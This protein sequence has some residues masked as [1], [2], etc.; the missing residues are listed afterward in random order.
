MNCY[1]RSVLDDIILSGY[2]KYTLLNMT[3]IYSTKGK[4]WLP[5]IQWW[6]GTMLKI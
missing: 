6:I 1:D 5:G 2:L 4:I 3:V